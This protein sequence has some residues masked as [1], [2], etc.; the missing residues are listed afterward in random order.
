MRI[1][2]KIPHAGTLKR[3]NFLSHHKLPFWMKNRIKIIRK[4][5][6]GKPCTVTGPKPY[7]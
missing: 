3:S 6:T 7:R 1:R 5:S 4:N 2:N